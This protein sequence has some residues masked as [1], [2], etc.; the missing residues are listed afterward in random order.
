MFRIIKQLYQ[1]KDNKRKY[2]LSLQVAIFL[3]A[4][5]LAVLALLIQPNAN[6][7]FC[8]KTNNNQTS[9]FCDFVLN[10][11][12]AHPEFSTWL[13]YKQL[14]VG[15]VAIVGTL[16]ILSIY[17]MKS[18]LVHRALEELFA[19]MS[20]HLYEIGIMGF[21][22]VFPLLVLPFS[23]LGFVILIGIAVWAVFRVHW[24]IKQRCLR[25]HRKYTDDYKRL[26][27]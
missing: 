19:R 11:G 20:H 22:I 10:F 14:L 25:K 9:Q 5:S 17:G 7:A 13:N 8:T 23:I 15:G 4:S 26:G 27:E 12:E 3:G 21:L 24:D 1:Y 2:E 6:S 16:F 18:A